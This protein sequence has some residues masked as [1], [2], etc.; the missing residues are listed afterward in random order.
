MTLITRPKERKSWLRTIL[1]SP[2]KAG[3]YRI[4]GDSPV[5][6]LPPRLL[7]GHVGPQI[8]RLQWIFLGT[9]VRL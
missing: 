2:S 5:S 1:T 6:G 7:G 8:R 4:S 9:N 3:L